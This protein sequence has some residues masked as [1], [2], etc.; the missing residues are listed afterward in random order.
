MTI[1][2]NPIPEPFANPPGYDSMGAR[3][4]PLKPDGGQAVFFGQSGFFSPHLRELNPKPKAS[5]AAA[6]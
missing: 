6:E 1:S 4:T 3:V 2:F 5:A